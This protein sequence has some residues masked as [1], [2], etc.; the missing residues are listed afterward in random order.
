MEVFTDS[1]D[2]GFLS[3]LHFCSPQKMCISRRCEE[4]VFHGQISWENST[5]KFR[6]HIRVVKALMV[7]HEISLFNFV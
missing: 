7:S 2:K 3:I 4:K 1:G 5:S 6:E